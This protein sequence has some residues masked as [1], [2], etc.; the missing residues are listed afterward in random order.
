MKKEENKHPL[1]SRS[2]IKAANEGDGLSAAEPER[3]VNTGQ[4]KFQDRELNPKPIM[5]E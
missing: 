1:I 4:K 2:I 3:I 5:Q